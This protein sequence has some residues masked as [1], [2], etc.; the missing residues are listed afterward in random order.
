MKK[1]PMPSTAI[2]ANEKVAADARAVRG[3]G[4]RGVRGPAEVGRAAGDHEARGRGEAAEQV[5]PVPDGVE[6]RERDVGRADLQGHEVVGE[7]ERDRG[8]VQQEHHRAV[9]GE[10]LIELLGGEEL[11]AGLRELTAHDQ[12]HEA[13][14]EEE[15]HR[16]D[17]VHDTDRLVIRGDHEVPDP[18]ADGPAARGFGARGTQPP[19]GCHVRGGRPCSTVHGSIVGREAAHQGSWRRRVANTLGTVSPRC[20]RSRRRATALG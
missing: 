9:H 16:R 7:A 12:R 6:P 4:Q 14:H 19:L 2:A 5:Q 8:R 3:V 18:A 10:Q 20:V 17:D 1:P 13:A 15:Q 11:Q